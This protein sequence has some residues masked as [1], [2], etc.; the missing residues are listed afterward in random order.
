MLLIK[1][2]EVEYVNGMFGSLFSGKWF[3]PLVLCWSLLVR[4]HIELPATNVFQSLKRSIDPD[5][6][7]I[8][9]INIVSLNGKIQQN[10][11]REQRR[12]DREV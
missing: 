4:D 11:W 6:G 7:M 12:D 5:L 10:T 9:D 1:S 2:E 3:T 8:I